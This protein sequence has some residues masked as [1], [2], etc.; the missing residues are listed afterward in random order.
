MENPLQ[1]PFTQQTISVGSAGAGLSRR[2]HLD[3]QDQPSK[4]FPAD[5]LCPGLSHGYDTGI[6]KG[7]D[8]GL[9]NETRRA[10][11]LQGSSF[12]SQNKTEGYH[13]D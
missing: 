9:V 8:L 3:G 11:R 12:L 10:I 1:S 7:V 2:C 5:G 6:S 13:Q 4:F